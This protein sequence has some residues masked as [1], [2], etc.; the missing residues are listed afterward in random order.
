MALA[1]ILIIKQGM[2]GGKETLFPDY[3]LRRSQRG[4]AEELGVSIG[5]HRRW[6]CWGGDSNDKAPKWFDSDESKSQ[7]LLPRSPLLSRT[8]APLHRRVRTV[9][10]HAV[11]A[12]AICIVLEVQP[13]RRSSPLKLSNSGVSAVFGP[14]RTDI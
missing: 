2:I 6:F 8:R 1:A 9:G 7:L 5:C 11:S 13:V 14:R 4:D 10:I 3:G 12:T